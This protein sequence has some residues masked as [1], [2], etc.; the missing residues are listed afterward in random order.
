MV[1]TCPT[2]KSS[3]MR[4]DRQSWG[5]D[6]I[7]KS[8]LP[9]HPVDGIVR[10][11]APLEL[12]LTPGV[13]VTRLRVRAFERLWPWVSDELELTVEVGKV[14]RWPPRCYPAMLV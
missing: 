3:G 4:G 2:S 1:L 11:T 12:T 9:T 13:A 10:T 6:V 14:N 7:Y 8:T 5:L